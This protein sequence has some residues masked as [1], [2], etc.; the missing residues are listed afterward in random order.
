MSIRSR[1]LLFQAIV[2]ASVLM[3]AAIVY[4]T[5]RSTNYYSQRV[6]W[7]NRQLEAVT[8]LT[9]NANRYSEQI[10]EFLLI[11][12]PE[13]SDYES[14]SAELEAGF[15]RLERLTRGE[16]EFL[17]GSSQQEDRGDEIFRITRMRTLSAEIS[18]A[19]S[20]AIDLRNQGR[21]EDAV[22]VF[23]RDIENRFDAE[24]ENILEAARRDE[25]E[26]VS[27]TELQA[28]VLWR[29]LTWTTAA[30]AAAAVLLCFAAAM[31]LARSLMRPIDLLTRGTEAISH[32]ELDHRISYDSRDELGALARR[33]NEMAENQEDQRDRLLNAKAELEQEVAARTAQLAAANQ[34]LTDLDR[35]RVQFLADI[36][37]ELRTPLTA[38]RGEAEIPLR[39]GSKPEA[40]Y[41]DALERIVTQSLEMGR[42]VDDLVFL[43]RSETDTIRFE[44]RRADLVTI[45]TDALHEGEILAR[46][47]G[48]SIAADYAIDPAWITA[49][50]QRLKQALLILL[51][52]AIKY[53]PRGSTVNLTMTAEGGHAQIAIR[54]KGLG[55]PAEEIPKV[56]ERF[57]RGRSPKT[58]RQPGSGLGLSIAKW[59]VEKHQGEIELESEVGAFTEVRVRIPCEDAMVALKKVSREATE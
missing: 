30:L 24:F 38:L 18:K 44:P 4:I 3:M 34:R 56:F 35:L 50:A 23:R 40:V 2:V 29:R 42:L 28:Q 55:I 57:Y 47:K 27:R 15:D 36:S 51:D 17:V 59:L 22:R 21:Q 25:E 8:A 26:E 37:H 52:N 45:V 58:S 39:H 31:L 49:D 54:D 5:I 43:S 20:E 6:Q 32:G 11:G 53:S 41:R 16:A 7:A 13:R 12:E 14:A 33:F 48:I 1:I 10:A 9:V 46:A 19:T